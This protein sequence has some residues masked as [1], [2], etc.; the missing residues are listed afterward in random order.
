MKLSSEHKLLKAK[1][2]KESEKFMERLIKDL[3]ENPDEP[4]TTLAVAIGAI[5]SILTEM[6]IS[7][8]ISEQALIALIEKFEGIND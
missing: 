7:A 8:E 2:K 5:Y 1:A 6:T 3:N 4:I